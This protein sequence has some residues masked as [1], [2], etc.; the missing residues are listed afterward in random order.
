MVEPRAT[1]A[2]GPELPLRYSFARNGTRLASPTATW[3]IVPVADLPGAPRLRGAGPS[4]VVEKRS[5]VT[6]AAAI[7][8]T[9][10]CAAAGMLATF[11]AEVG[12]EAG[13]EAVAAVTAVRKAATIS[14]ALRSG[15]KRLVAF[16]CS[17]RVGLEAAALLVG[18]PLAVIFDRCAQAL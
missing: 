8:A 17:P 14:G 13:V 11:G 4:I 7:F 15:T 2:S 6:A 9:S 3:A 1:S 18:Q 10:G 16:T 12:V 5:L